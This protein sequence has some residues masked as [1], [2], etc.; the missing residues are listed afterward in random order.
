MAPKSLGRT[1]LRVRLLLSLLAVCVGAGFLASSDI[2]RALPSLP[3]TP[4]VTPIKDA[5]GVLG[6]T[7]V[8]GGLNQTTS[9]VGQIV[10]AVNGLGATITGTAT[11]NVQDQ[12]AALQASI[13]AVQA[14]ILAVD[15]TGAQADVMAAVSAIEAQVLSLGLSTALTSGLQILQNVLSPVC[16]VTAVPTSFV[17]GLGVDLSRVYKAASP[18]IEQTDARTDT[19]IKNIYNTVYGDLIA[20]LSNNP[21]TA[22]VPALLT[23]LQFNWTTTYQKPDGT[24]I[25]KQMPGLINLPTPIDVDNSGTFDVCA[26]AGYALDPSG[27]VVMKQTITKMPLAKAVLPLK[28]EAPMV[29]GLLT[30][31]YDTTKQPF[32]DTDPSPTVDNSQSTAPVSY[33]ATTTYA[34]ALS[35]FDTA[36]AVHRGTTL[37]LPPVQAT[38]QLPALPTV[39]PLTE[40][41]ATPKLTQELCLLSCGTAAQ[42][43]RY[44]NEPNE[45]HVTTPGGPAA[46]NENLTYTGSS[47][48]DLYRQIY[49]VAGGLTTVSAKSVPAPTSLAY[50]ASSTKSICSNSPHA[51]TDTAS[52]KFT[53]SSPV[54]F[55]NSATS[56]YAPPTSTCASRAADVHVNG[57]KLVMSNTPATASA[58]GKVWVDTGDQPITGC[59][60]YASSVT[61]IPAATFV[62]GS[63]ANGRN[64][65]Y[66]L[67]GSTLIPDTKNGTAVCPSG[68]TFTLG[69]STALSPV[70]CPI[71]AAIVSGP[72]ITGEPVVE[73]PLLA[74]STWNPVADT[75]TVAN[76]P[77]L[78]YQWSKCTDTGILCNPVAGAT[79]KTYLPVYPDDIG[80]TFRVT[81]KGINSDGSV[82]SAPSPATPV[83]QD[84]TVAPVNTVLPTITGVAG[85]GHTL[86][87]HSS[88]STDW[89]Q[90]VSGA[91][92]YQ[93]QK[94]DAS[95][96]SCADIT[97]ATSSTYTPVYPTDLDSTIQVV[98]TATNHVG[99]T[100]ATSAQSRIQPAPVNT[101]VGT[102]VR[103]LNTACTTTAAIPGS[104]FTGDKL[105]VTD[106]SWQAGTAT[107]FLYQWEQCDETGANCTPIAGATTN[108]YTVSKANDIGKTLRAVVSGTNDNLDDT[109]AAVKTPTET[110]ATAVVTPAKPALQSAPAVDGI[111]NSVAG[112]GHDTTF[113]GG[114]FDTAGPA[115]G[116]AGAEVLTAG[117]TLGTVANGAGVSGGVVKAIASDSAGGYII[118]GNFSHVQGLSCP[119]FAHILNTGALDATY[120]GLGISGEVRAVGLSTGTYGNASGLLTTYSTTTKVVIGGLFSAGGHA[121][122]IYVDPST[123]AIS[124]DPLGDPNGAVNAFAAGAVTTG[125]LLASPP[126]A[127]TQAGRLYVGGDFTKLGA[128]TANHLYRVNWSTSNTTTYPLNQQTSVAQATF[129]YDSTYTPGVACSSSCLPANAT[130]N[131]LAAVTGGVIAG[132]VFDGAFKASDVPSVRNNAAAFSTTAP[133]AVTTWDPNIGGPVYALGVGVAPSGGTTLPVVI[134]GAFATASGGAASNV[135]EYGIVTASGAKSTAAGTTMS[136][137]P[138]TSW[139]P[140]VDGPVHAISMGAA[141]SSYIALGGA[142]KTAEGAVSHR[143]A[144]YANQNAA[145]TAGAALQPLTAHAGNTVYALGR[146][147]ASRLLAGGAFKVLGGQIRNNVAEISQASGVTSF[148]ADTDGP[149]SAV[150]ANADNVYLAGSFSKVNGSN[151][152]GL[153]AVQ[154]SDSVVTSWTPTVSGGSVKSMAAD[155]NRVYLGGSF[156]GVNSDSRSGLAAVGAGVGDTSVWNPAL[157][158]GAT[159]NS[160]VLNGGSVLAGGSFSSVGSDPRSNAA[161]I[162]TTTGNATA[163]SPNPD[164]TVNTIAVDPDNADAI[165]LGGSFANAGGAARANLAKVNGSDGSAVSGWQADTDG[166]VNALVVF[167]GNLYLAGTYTTTGGNAYG[168]MSGIDANTGEV[169]DWQPT[170]SGVIRTMTLTSSGLLA[171]GGDFV[172]FNP[173]VTPTNATPVFSYR[174]GFALLG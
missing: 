64:V 16:A 156:T 153:G 27:A 147:A 22:A 39:M 135:V 20:I 14:D 78:Y 97:D 172:T 62:T 59:V 118:G 163:W 5:G 144:L 100:A 36:V 119:G 142:F 31:G 136:G 133:G 50:C 109:N 7:N 125:S 53:S 126:A 30:V 164:G 86:T 80:S 29:L 106:G 66:H 143:I 18:L 83:I 13:A 120:C 11:P 32:Y 60:A 84:Q 98:V 45:I 96:L 171:I 103:C 8:S 152:S 154:Q 35:K 117:A 162:S 63:K 101:A 41:A 132:G 173:P 87:A 169:L 72:T 70:V 160:V 102:I 24:T 48:G 95:G 138:S 57:T 52:L 37:T 47:R 167:S 104:P 69:S 157:N 134:G 15:P 107:A 140:T 17:P 112:S 145:A 40:P 1:R 99:S 21:N 111:V 155:A 68:A 88:R 123:K 19:L 127:V 44:D 168:P 122:L 93:W 6:V 3:T 159:V 158:S 139:K 26:M 91:L 161:A 137:A 74:N 128:T 166:A 49:S 116:G 38:A 65:Q 4:T 79:D 61:G 150:A 67:S 90:G 94:C 77:T 28:I 131:A 130:V 121:N 141:S 43:H 165:F 25:T 174:P 108:R 71:T 85:T 54:Q 2:A 148:K 46:A 105:K 124:G 55:D 81:V 146:D 149:V 42:F 89:S 113:L 10:G 110:A 170:P 129:T 56:L 12:V 114:A 82:T 33:S 23:L 151:R 34:S 92:T 115:V 76:S 75:P 51:S 58:P 73:S 9:A